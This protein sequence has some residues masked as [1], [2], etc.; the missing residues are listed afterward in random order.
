MK[1]KIRPGTAIGIA[2]CISGL[3]LLTRCSKPAEHVPSFDP[4]QVKAE[5]ESR[6]KDF[7]EALR[8]GNLGALRD[9]Y[10][11]DAQVLNSGVPTIVGREDIMKTF[12]SMVRDSATISG[13]ETTDVW[14]SDSLVVE[15]GTG[16]FEHA[17]G[18]WRSTGRYLL[19]WKKVDGEWKIF[20]DTWFADK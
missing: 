7:S 13:F 16:F 6:G 9:L 12:G 19:V 2:V 17:A 14:G 15:Q 1:T 3:V 20:R 11:P 10:T 18:K 4:V 8:D 5:I